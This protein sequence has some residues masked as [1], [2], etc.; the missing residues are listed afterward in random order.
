MDLAHLNHALDSTPFAGKLHHFASIDSTNTHAMREAANSAPASSVYVADEQ[1]AGRGRGAHAWHSESASGLY[2]S[3]LLRPQLTAADSLWLSLAAGLAAHD[4]VI[5]V[6]RSVP[7]IRWPNDLMITQQ[8]MSK[9]FGGILTE[10]QT[11]GGRLRHAVVGIGINVNHDSFPPEIAPFATSL[12]LATGKPQPR[13]ALLLALLRSFHE[14]VTSLESTLPRGADIL[15]RIPSA[16]TWI[17]GKRVHV[18]DH[19]IPSG[20]F[21]GVTAGLDPRGFLLIDT[22]AGRRTVFSGGVREALK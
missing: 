10:I 9:K 12:R 13:E 21:T 18:T 15:R 17:S 4:A 8:Q 6:T 19:D 14:E 3:I 1:T 5:E 2:V 20:G 16:S 7:D 11:D 22:P